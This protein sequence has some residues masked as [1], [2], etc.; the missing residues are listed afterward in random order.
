MTNMKPND[1]VVRYIDACF[2]MMTVN[3]IP[4]IEKMDK[5]MNTML[6]FNGADIVRL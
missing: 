6:M 2:S 1:A 4:S 3:E 5:D